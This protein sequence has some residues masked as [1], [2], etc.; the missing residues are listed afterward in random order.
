VRTARSRIR[1]ADVARPASRHI[2]YVRGASDRVPEALQRA[3]LAVTVLDAEAL[4]HGDF[5]AYDVIVIGSRAYETDSAL[6]R[7]NDR[8]LAWVRAGGH[9]VV[10]YQQYQWVRG[11]FAP[12]P[13]AIAQPHDRITDETSPVTVLIL[14]HPVFRWPNAITE[15][16]W[17]D[18][19]QERGLYFAGTWDAAFT[20]L[21]EMRDPGGPPLRGGLLVAPV[22]QGTYVYTGLSFFRA[23]PAGVPGAFRLFFNLLDLGATMDR[24]TE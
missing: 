24:G 7:H 16:D 21:L 13:I 19:P 1:V 2:G 9:L 14:D 22:G 4:A 23:L 12:F 11:G 20:P 6:V 18:W 10:Q 5:A 17:D 8:L 3:G 15:A